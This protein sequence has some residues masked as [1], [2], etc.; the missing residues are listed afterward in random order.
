M[1]VVLGATGNTGSV[2][3]KS[4]L[5]PGEKVRVVGRDAGKLAQLTQL[6]A[7]SVTADA[8]DVTALTKAFDGATAAYVLLRTSMHF[9]CGRDRSWKIFCC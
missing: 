1:Y 5:K 9:F 3:A 4:L 7:E 2:L 6:G 8:A